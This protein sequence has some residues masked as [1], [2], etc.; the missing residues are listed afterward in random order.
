MARRKGDDWYIGAMTNEQGRTLSVPLD[1]LA[2]GRRYEA[3]IYQDAADPNRLRHGKALV[4]PNGRLKLTLSSSGG[5]A[6]VLKP[7]P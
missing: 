7:A 3:S 1:F 2:A 5:A 6:A 4:R